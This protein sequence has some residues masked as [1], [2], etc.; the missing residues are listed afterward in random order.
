[1]YQELLI[2]VLFIRASNINKK[3]NFVFKNDVLVLG[4]L[5]LFT[6]AISF[7][8]GFSGDS[9]IE[10]LHDCFPL[11]LIYSFSKLFTDESEIKRMDSFLF[12]L[13][14]VAFASQ[15]YTFFTGAYLLDYFTDTT[16]V[17]SK[18]LLAGGQ[19]VARVYNCVFL[20]MYTFHK[21]LLYYFRQDNSFNKTY[22]LALII[23]PFISLLLSA[24]RG[25]I[26]AFI[27]VFLISG[28]IFGTSK[29]VVRVIQ[30]VV[31]VIIIF[32]V[33]NVISP[34]IRQ[35]FDQAIERFSTIS[36][37]AQ[38]DLS[39]GGTSIRMSERGPRVMEKVMERPFFGWGF[40][41]T[42]FMFRDGHVG[43]HTL[44]LNVGIFGY[45]IFLVVFIRWVILTYRY[46]KYQYSVKEYGKTII[47]YTLSLIFIFTVHSTSRQFWGFTLGDKATSFMAIFLL[48]TSF[49][50]DIKTCLKNKI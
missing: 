8:N 24:T 30:M 34:I 5:L 19:D 29:R 40:S 50:V 37:I 6:I 43:H 22:L 42:Y 45:L 35:Q 3:W 27:I 28:I 26:L 16:S 4:L 44:L 9:S 14:F 47:I 1:M 18:L 21:A 13:V 20:I 39:A 11:L 38:G 17:D 36:S 25:W 23:V 2:A 32:I 15:I 41:D 7:V 10:M 31:G 46:S 33:M 48:L 12:P 49:N